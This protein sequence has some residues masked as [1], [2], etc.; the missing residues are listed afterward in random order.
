MRWW[1]RELNEM[2]DM[3]IDEMDIWS[4]IE[5]PFDGVGAAKQIEY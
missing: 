4:L 2:V 1:L 3:H 5:V